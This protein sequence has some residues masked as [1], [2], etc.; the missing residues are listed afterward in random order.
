MSHWVQTRIL[1][2]TGT[3]RIR[4]FHQ[5]PATP[6]ML[7]GDNQSVF[8]TEA[9]V[10]PRIPPRRFSTWAEFV[11]AEPPVPTNSRVVR[12]GMVTE[13]DNPFP[14][15]AIP[16]DAAARNT[17]NKV[18]LE[19][20]RQHA[21][22]R[23]AAKAERTSLMRLAFLALVGI[24]VLTA[25]VFAFVVVD[26]VWL[27]DKTA[28]PLSA[29]LLGLLATI[30]T[31]TGGSGRS[32]LRAVPTVAV[33]LLSISLPKRAIGS[34]EEVVVYDYPHTA[35][36]RAKLP[37]AEIIPHL[38][39]NSRWIYNSRLPNVLGLIL[40]IPVGW[41]FFTLLFYVFFSI[42]YYGPFPYWAFAATF[43]FLIGPAVGAFLG[44][45]MGARLGPQNFWIVRKYEGNV[46]LP[47]PHTHIDREMVYM[48]RT[49][50]NEDFTGLPGSAPKDSSVK[51]GTYP[52]YVPAVHRA[53]WYKKAAELKAYKAILNDSYSDPKNSWPRVQI[54]GL[55]VM[56][57]A[58]I[59]IVAFT[60]IAT[61]K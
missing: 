36:W 47:F 12:L 59:I 21:T 1:E 50:I 18:Q 46:I 31:G 33:R 29:S 8:L 60:V 27:K 15:G 7:H 16:P 20:S 9:P 51:S 28:T 39:S 55:I 56:G 23:V 40:G 54:S 49:I 5:N 43:G 41:L 17:D 10:Y 14:R 52:E 42:L 2:A 13:D 57:I 48:M 4:R 37:L 25:I 44:W 58:L 11:A 24:I 53:T 35:I 30:V 38:P 26:N 61:Q 6:L 34:Y 19:E 32:I 45:H 22:T 3:Y